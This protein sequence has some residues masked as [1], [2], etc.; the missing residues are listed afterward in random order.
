MHTD[1][2][3]PGCER[4]A[5]RS[6]HRF[7][8]RFAECC[9]RFRIPYNSRI[10]PPRVLELRC[11]V[12]APRCC[13]AVPLNAAP[14]AVEA[15]YKVVANREP[16]RAAIRDRAYREKVP[17]RFLRR[18]FPGHEERS[19]RSRECL[20]ATSGVSAVRW[21]RARFVQTSGA[22]KKPASPEW[23]RALDGEQVR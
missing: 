9:H 21:Y 2:L 18:K 4:P 22:L 17:A 15:G 10:R 19:G 20:A 3:F 7:S 11:G 12:S 13:A 16:C 23:C 8:K 14:D 5:R 1:L 6:W